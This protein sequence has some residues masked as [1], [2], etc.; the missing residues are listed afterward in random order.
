M[1]TRNFSISKWLGISFEF[2]TQLMLVTAIF[3]FGAIS[4]PDGIFEAPLAQIPLSAA[5]AA[6]PSV[7][8]FALGL[9]G[10]YFLAVVEPF[11]RSYE[12]LPSR[13]RE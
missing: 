12:Q 10:L 5:I 7:F 9:S 1:T 13:A 6:A 11:S 4:W 8:A 3:T 2:L